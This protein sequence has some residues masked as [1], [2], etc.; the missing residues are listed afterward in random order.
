MPKPTLKDIAD[1]AGV[2]SS[3]ASLV[4]SNK[5]KISEEVKQKVVAIADELGYPRRAQS[6][7]VS[8]GNIAV[9]F[10]FDSKLAHTWHV[11]RQVTLQLEQTLASNN[12][13]LVLIPI[14]YEMEDEQIFQRVMALKA[15]AVFSMH[16]GRE[17]LFS[18]LE[19]AAIPVVVIINSHFQSHFY[20]VCADNFQGSYEAASHLVRLGH[21]QIIYADFNIHELPETLI[22]RFFGFSKALNEHNIPFS[23]DQKIRLDVYDPVDIKEK[24]E[25]LLSSKKR[26]TAIFFVDDYL[27]ARCYP[28]LQELGYRIPE[29]LSIIAS[30]EVLD[31]NEPFIPRITGMLTNSAL[32][33]KFSAEMMVDRLKLKP[34]ESYVLKIKQQ[35][36]E[37]GSCKA[38]G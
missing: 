27:A 30:G 11:L 14:T 33:G 24:L 32:L 5:G 34:R 28:I 2:S 7:T 13:V 10:H 25:A 3:T 16:F 4:L 6:P 20:T 38:I 21:K 8:S 18:R 35:L 9:L 17:A 31:Y 29:D 1:R 12:Y 19:E 23:E 37:R 36:M 15:T 22:D 26:P